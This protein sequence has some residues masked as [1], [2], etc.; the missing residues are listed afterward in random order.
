[1][2]N[3][4]ACYKGCRSGNDQRA[5]EREQLSATENNRPVAQINSDLAVVLHK[6][7]S[8]CLFVYSNGS[9]MLSPDF[10][11]TTACALAAAVR[12]ISIPK[13]SRQNNVDTSIPVMAF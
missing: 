8:Q 12:R 1:M 2:Q 9:L 3:S 11:G 5:D 13:R 10:D 4:G 6:V 7:E